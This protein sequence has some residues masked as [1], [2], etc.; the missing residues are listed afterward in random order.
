MSML[1]EGKALEQAEVIRLLPLPLDRDHTFAGRGDG[2]EGTVREIDGSTGGAGR[3][4]VGDLSADGGTGVGPLDVDP[5][6][7]VAG[8]RAVVTVVRR[9]DGD[10]V[11]AVRVVDSTGTGVSV[12]V[13]VGSIGVTDP[14]SA[15]GSLSSG[16]SLRGGGS[17]VGLGGWLNV[18]RGG[19]SNPFGS[20]GGGSLLRGGRSD[21]LLRRGSGLGLV[22]RRGRGDGGLEDV[23]GVGSGGAGTGSGLGQG[24]DGQ[25]LGGGGL[26]AGDSLNNGS[27]LIAELLLSERVSRGGNV[28]ALD[29]RQSLVRGDTVRWPGLG[30]VLGS[31]ERGA[32]VKE[33]VVLVSSV[34]VVLALDGQVPLVVDLVV[35]EV[36]AGVTGGGS[37]GD[38][39][40]SSGSDVLTLDGEGSD[41][42]GEGDED[43][44]GFDEHLERDVKVF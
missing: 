37:L 29:G 24:D 30:D 1:K 23:Q 26:N 13:E 21:P 10:D 32:A 27:S 41:G 6:S 44:S 33:E 19:R 12:L 7:T 40:G 8:S 31:Q 20:G 22:G 38:V 36:T 14:V 42:A 2:S 34:P 3:A 11:S 9:R 35:L 18:S 25:R 43:G 4:D 28:L 16:R 15:R 17:D 5:P 39:R